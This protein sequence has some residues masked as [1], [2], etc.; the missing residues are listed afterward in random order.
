MTRAKSD[1]CDA[2]PQLVIHSSRLRLE[3]NFMAESVVQLVSARSRTIMQASESHGLRR[4][5]TVLRVRPFFLF[6][7]FFPSLMLIDIGIIRPRSY[8]IDPK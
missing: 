5:S 7:F 6:P 4:V 2:V 8:L 3:S 1:T